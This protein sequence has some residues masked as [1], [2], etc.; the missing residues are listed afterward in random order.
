MCLESHIGDNIEAYVDDV[1]VKTTV[2]DN[3]IVDLAQT[4]ANLQRYHWKLNSEKC[5]FDIPSGKL[6]GFM[7]SQ[8]ASR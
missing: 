2:E 3:L 8:W 4:F 1:V 5:I 7:V 6:V